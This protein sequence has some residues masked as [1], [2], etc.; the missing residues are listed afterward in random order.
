MNNQ[1]NV[2]HL[3]R[4]SKFVQ[5]RFASLTRNTVVSPS[6]RKSDLRC[7]EDE[8]PTY[9]EHGGPPTKRPP[10]SNLGLGFNG[11]Q[12]QP[13]WYG[14]LNGGLALGWRHYSW[15]E[16]K[17]LH[18]HFQEQVVAFT[19]AKVVAAAKLDVESMSTKPC[20]LPLSPDTV[21]TKSIQKH[22]KNINSQT[23]TEHEWWYSCR[24]WQCRIESTDKWLHPLGGSKCVKDM[25]WTHPI[26]RSCPTQ[27]F[28]KEVF[29]RKPPSQS[30][31][32][33]W[34]ILNVN[35]K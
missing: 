12:W 23:W 5:M 15:E 7:S 33:T 32:Q 1:E 10:G 25:D 19:W 18:C 4:E 9:I 30:T 21:H 13:F 16:A 17:R 20:F 2:G 3:R 29:S 28:I 31:Q 26:P 6:S 34:M 35:N 11:A 22:R 14:K 27:S 8:A 24:I